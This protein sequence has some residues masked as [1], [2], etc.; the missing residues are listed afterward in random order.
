MK[1]KV[2]KPAPTIFTV[3]QHPQVLVF[4]LRFVR[5][6]GKKQESRKQKWNCKATARLRW[7]VKAANGKGGGSQMENE[8]G[9]EK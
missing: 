9:I 7:S 5:K 8:D 6:K 4:R 3:S 2:S 1:G